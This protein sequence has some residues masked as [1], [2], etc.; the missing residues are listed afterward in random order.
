MKTL[1]LILLCIPTLVGGANYNRVANESRVIE[2]KDGKITVTERSIRFKKLFHF[3]NSHPK[4][5]NN[6]LTTEIIY[7]CDYPEVMAAIASVESGFDSNAIGPCNEVSVWQILEW[8]LGDPTNNKDGLAAALKVFREKRSESRSNV[9]AIRRY[10]G[11]GRKAE[12][13][14]RKVLNKI[15]QIQ[16]T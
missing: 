10:N 7:A 12:I 11:R 15:K 5:N 4:S 2:N 14:Q 13:Y 1:L 3:I 6:L 8:K 16:S 9:E